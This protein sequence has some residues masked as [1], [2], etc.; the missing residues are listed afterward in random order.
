MPLPVEI[1]A[2]INIACFKRLIKTCARGKAAVNELM[3]FISNFFTASAFVVFF[4]FQLH[5][6]VYKGWHGDLLHQL[7]CFLHIFSP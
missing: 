5:G 2:E 7:S 3:S 6:T 1:F 4:F